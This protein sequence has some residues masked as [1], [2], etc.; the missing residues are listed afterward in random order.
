M[1]G[2]VELE[3]M[4]KE[5]KSSKSNWLNVSVESTNVSK[6]GNCLSEISESSVVEGLSFTSNDSVGVS[7]STVVS[8][9]DEGFSDKKGDQ[10]GDC[11][12]EDSSLR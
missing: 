11:L 6:N 3:N 2:L 5:D 1:E 7:G 4:F 12:V 9:E 8:R 10:S